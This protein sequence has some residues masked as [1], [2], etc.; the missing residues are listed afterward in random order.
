MWRFFERQRKLEA[1]ACESLGQDLAEMIRK[2]QLCMC[3]LEQIAEHQIS[4]SDSCLDLDCYQWD[5]IDSSQ[6]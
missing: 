4:E 1:R 5:P 6:I 2:S 3:E